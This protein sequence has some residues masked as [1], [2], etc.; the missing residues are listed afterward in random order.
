MFVRG[1]RRCR[2]ISAKMGVYTVRNTAKL[3]N[4]NNENDS[5]GDDDMSGN[6]SQHSGS[7]D[8]KGDSSEADGFDSDS[9]ELDEPECDRRTAGFVKYMGEFA[10]YFCLHGTIISIYHM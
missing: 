6:E 10:L 3:S 2:K 8:Q 7:S 5:D 9:S 4:M 1:E